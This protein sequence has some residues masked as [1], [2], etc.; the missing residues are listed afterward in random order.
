MF[1]GENAEDLQNPPLIYDYYPHIHMLQVHSLP[2]PTA[3]AAGCA[4]WAVARVR[5][6]VARKEKKRGRP[7]VDTWNMDHESGSDNSPLISSSLRGKQKELREDFIFGC[8]VCVFFFPYL[9]FPLLVPL[10]HSWMYKERERRDGRDTG[11]A[12]SSQN[13]Q[14]QWRE[15][16]Q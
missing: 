6:V 13:Y 12:G 16:V 1:R 11:T 4:E 7:G 3:A 10:C 5:R 9:R 8:F 14:S 15:Y 2:F